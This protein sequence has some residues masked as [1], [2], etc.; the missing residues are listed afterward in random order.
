MFLTNCFP[1][2]IEYFFLKNPQINPLILFLIF[3]FCYICLFE[4][5]EKMLNITSHERNVNQN[6]NEISLDTCKDEHYKRKT[7]SKKITSFGED[8]EDLEP[9]CM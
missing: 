7:F 5:H 2:K 8:M 9:L 3:L 1:Q 4:A 6:H